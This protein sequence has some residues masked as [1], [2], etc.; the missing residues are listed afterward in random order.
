[1]IS[2][3]T[4]GRGFNRDTLCLTSMVCQLR[5]NPKVRLRAEDAEDA[6][7]KKEAIDLENLVSVRA[8]FDQSCRYAPVQRRESGF[9]FGR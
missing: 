2:Q 1:M 8:A 4:N 6:E 9:S 7:V 5:L 3:V